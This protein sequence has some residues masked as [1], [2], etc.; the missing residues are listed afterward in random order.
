MFHE[1]TLK[2]YQKKK[3]HKKGPCPVPRAEKCQDLAK[4]RGNLQWCWEVAPLQ[5][6]QKGKVL[7]EGWRWALPEN[8]NRSAK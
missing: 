4:P 2:S 7:P 8:H 5:T 3:P 6:P 1:E